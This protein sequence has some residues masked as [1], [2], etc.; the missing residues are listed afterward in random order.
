[1]AELYCTAHA[2]Y[3]YT[4]ELVEH[5]L[6]G[7]ISAGEPDYE[8]LAAEARSLLR[9][10][11]VRGPLYLGLS[12][13]FLLLRTG[14]FPE[15][16]GFPLEE[17]VLAEAERSPFWGQHALA[18]DYERLDPVDEHR[19]RVLYAA[20]PSEAVRLLQARLRPRRIEPL[21]LVVWR[22]ARAALARRES[23]IVLDAV[24]N[25]MALFEQGK[26]VDFRLLAHPIA[27]GGRALADEVGR[28]LQLF[29]RYE[30]VEVA[31][32]FDLPEPPPEIEGL[33]AGEVV[34]SAQVAALK[35]AAWRRE[36][37]WLELRPR[38]RRLGEGLPREA[39][40]ALLW[41]ALWLALGLAGQAALRAELAQQQTINRALRAEVARLE[42]ARPLEEGGPLPEGVTT[43]LV[44][45]VTAAL[46]DSTWLDEMRVDEY[47]LVLR[48][49]SL[50]PRAPQRLARGLNAPP[51]WTQW[52]PEDEDFVW[53]VSLELSQ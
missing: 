7:V 11:R 25:S 31:W 18:V 43:D 13:E 23:W 53:E 45:R 22:A 20:M 28:S 30:P 27:E 52:D 3:L 38:R 47:K 2:L 24:T 17:A 26:L 4:T 16:E 41:S 44:R 48:G 49:R 10:Q 46:P 32:L 21:P 37:P 6:E 33:P 9:A 15:L 51:A 8:R 29:G 35:D 42:A 36:P 1:M 50:E 40:R 12:P 5:P 19:R 14:L 39:Q 34:R